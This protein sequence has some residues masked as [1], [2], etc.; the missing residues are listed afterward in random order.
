MP[1]LDGYAATRAIRAREEKTVVPRT[2]IV[3]MTANSMS[4]DRDRCLAAGMDDYLAKPLDARA[5][6][7]SLER[8]AP[9]AGDSA[10]VLD[11]AAFER[12]RD[13][14]GATDL[15]TRLLDIFRTQTPEHLETLRVAV[16]KGDAGE[17]SRI[18][19]TLKGGAQTLAASR[20][21]ALCRTLEERGRKGSLASAPA[22]VAN[23]EAAFDEARD[24]LAAEL[25]QAGQREVH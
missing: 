24:A 7:A 16:F 13:D 23:I 21:A 20:M 10:P 9:V 4:G 6:D 5:F 8:W 25:A 19:H 12:L 17:A 1:E 14:L 11:R 15:L 22:L 18:A 2:P 3:A